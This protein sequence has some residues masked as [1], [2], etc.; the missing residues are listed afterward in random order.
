MGGEGW[1]DFTGWNGD[2][3]PMQQ[4]KGLSCVQ[5]ALMTSLKL[6]G[7]GSNLKQWNICNL[8]LRNDSVV[9]VGESLSEE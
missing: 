4:S 6:K 8:N 5:V 2:I 9:A 1:A 7:R 3:Q